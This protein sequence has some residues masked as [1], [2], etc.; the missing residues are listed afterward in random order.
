MN[1]L[2]LY[3]PPASGKSTL[4]KAIVDL[5][6]GHFLYRLL[7]SEADNINYRPFTQSTT[8]VWES[9]KYGRRY[10]IDLEGFHNGLTEGLIPIVQ[11]GEPEALE[12]LRA[13]EI[14]WTV[15][16]LW[17]PRSIAEERINK[18]DSGEAESRMAAW[19]RTEPVVAD[20]VFSTHRVQVVEILDE[21]SVYQP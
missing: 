19:D 17:C 13:M 16:Y 5:G 11:L 6:Q 1:G 9:T 15:L 4:A 18:R 7:R 8:T 20:R 12:A 2:V 21:I 14:N 10:G 3:G